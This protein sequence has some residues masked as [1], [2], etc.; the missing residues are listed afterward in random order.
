MK[1]DAVKSKTHTKTKIYRDKRMRCA[2]STARF[3]ECEQ[4]IRHK[5]IN[6][7]KIIFFLY[8]MIFKCKIKQMF[9]NDDD[10]N[11]LIYICY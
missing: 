3:T 5:I 8:D 11:S 9:N 10:N 7:F 4:K 1:Q 2:A 6:V